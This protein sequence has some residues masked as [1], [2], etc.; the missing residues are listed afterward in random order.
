MGVQFKLNN[1]AVK[2]FLQFDFEKICVYLNIYVMFRCA[3]VAINCNKDN[4][5]IIAMFGFVYV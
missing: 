2:E 4:K 1:L 3:Y 5:K